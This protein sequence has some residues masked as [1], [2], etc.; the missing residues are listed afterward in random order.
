[1]ALVPAPRRARGSS[2]TILISPSVNERIREIP[3]LFILNCTLTN[4]IRRLALLLRHLGEAQI[5]VQEPS[6]F[7]A[8]PVKL[9][10]VVDDH[11]GILHPVCCSVN[12]LLHKFVD[13]PF[14][15]YACVAREESN[16]EAWNPPDTR[17]LVIRA[18]VRRQ[19][20]TSAV[21]T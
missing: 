8:M 15:S 16:L 9:A 19:P 14:E 18:V 4:R 12:A 1:M 17:F 3:E 2:G 20:V 13:Y 5:T 6:S 10:V 11:G 21:A 7:R